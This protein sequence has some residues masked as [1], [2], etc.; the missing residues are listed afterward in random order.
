[1]KVTARGLICVVLLGFLSGIG[2][3]F[4]FWTN[5]T[6]FSR[7]QN[8]IDYRKVNVLINLEMGMANP[9]FGV[10]YGNWSEEWYK[11]FH[12]IKGYDIPDLTDGNHNT[13]LGRFAELGFIGLILYLMIFYHMFR[14]GLRVYRKSEGYE[15]GFSLIF[16]L[17]LISYIIGASFSDYRNSPFLNIT[18]FLLFGA[19]AGIE[20]QMASRTSFNRTGPVRTLYP[21]T[22]FRQQ[23]SEAVGTHAGL[24]GQLYPAMHTAVSKRYTSSRN[25]RHQTRDA[26]DEPKD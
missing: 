13:F 1:M 23:E 11:Y 9:I 14:I 10:G 12:A 4:S 24:P 20:E 7:R 6:L 17:I 21:K 18:L 22:T 19:V 15:R 8:T 16:L 5:R 25:H 3:H 26:V 2:S